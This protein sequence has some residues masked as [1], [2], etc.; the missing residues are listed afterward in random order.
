[1]SE[2]VS[3]MAV[4]AHQRD[5]R[6][7]EKGLQ[8]AVKLEMSIIPPYL[9]AAWSIDTSQD[10]SHTQD[11]IVDIAREEMLHM[12]IACNLLASI[13]GQ[14]RIV[15]AAPRYPTDLPKHI[16]QG[17]QVA[18]EPLSR[19]LLLRKFMVIE[20]PA[21][22]VVEDHEFVPSGSKLIGEF[23]DAVQHAFEPPR[24][25]NFSTARQID[26]DPFFHKG[27]FVVANLD[28]VRRGIDL[29]KRQGE[30]TSAKPFENRADPNDLAHFYQFGEIAHGR[31]LTR[32]APFAYTSDEVVQMPAVRT[33]APADPTAPAATQFNR[34]YSDMLGDLDRAWDGGGSAALRAARSKMFALGAPAEQMIQQGVGPPFVVVDASGSPMGPPDPGP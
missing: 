26:L 1:M 22:L 4:P 16:H 3:L 33:V 24:P 13:G 30:G 10:P 11:V 31:R 12:G 34:R 8:A 14:P 7:L 9:Y 28:D 15:Q 21:T 20:E 18:L 2:L 5:D 27:S 25:P 29:I 6:W 23:Y 19:D 32:T 17:L